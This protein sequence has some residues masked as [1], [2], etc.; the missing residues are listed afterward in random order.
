[1]KQNITGNG[2]HVQEINRMLSPGKAMIKETRILLLEDIPSDAELN[3]RELR[4]ANLVYTSKH[5]DTKEAFL[6]ALTNFSP[7][8][9]LS[10]YGLPQFNG[11][12]ALQL[13]KELKLDIPFI[14]V[15]GSLTEEV[16]VACMKEGAAD[17]ILKSSLKRLPSAVLNA[18]E[19]HEANRAKEEAFAALR[20]AND[21]LERRVE[22]RTAE[23]AKTNLFLREEIVVRKRA[24][25][26][27]RRREK[28][29]ADFVDNATIGLHWVDG[30]GTILWANKA[31]LELLGYT[32]EEY[33]GHHVAEFYADADVITD[34]LQ[35]L[36]ANEE[37]H[38]YEARLRCKDGSIR[39]VHINS[40]VYWEDGK[41]VHTRCFTRDIT[42]RRIAEEALRQAHD[43]LEQRVEQ[44]TAELVAA[45]SLLKDEIRER[46]RA[47]KFLLE[48][49]MRFHS[50][51]EY[52]PIG[53]GLA[54][55]EGRWLQV[56]DSFCEIV[57]YTKNELLTLDFQTITHP[58]DL[59][60]TFQYQ[61]RM[62]TG[63]VKTC[64]IEKRYI[65]K[66]GHV[67]WALTNVSLL[68]DEQNKPLYFISQ[69]QDVTERKRAEEALKIS[70]EQLR[71]S[72]K[73]EAVGQLAG[74]IAHDFN[75]L[76]T[77]INGYSEL[78]LRRLAPDSP[79]RN[80][81]EEI[82]K[83][84]ERAA[85]LTRQLLAFSRKQVLQ[86]K[87]LNLNAI[88]TDMDKMLR[89]LIGA[90]VDILT[91][92][93]SA[94]G[95]VKADAG[96]LEQVLMNLAVNARD[97]MPA[98]GKLT[99]QT[100]NVELSEENSQNHTS[101]KPGRYVMLAVSDTG[102][103]MD[104]ETQSR[105]FEPFFT[106]KEQGKGTGLGLSTVYGIV[107]QS[108]GNIQIYSE[109]GKGTTFKIHLPRVD[110]TIDTPAP[111]KLSETAVQAVETVL[112]VE[113]EP[114]VRQLSRQ[115]LE[116]EGYRVFEAALASEALQFC[117]NYKDEIQI[118][119]TDMVMPE[120]NG[121][122]L[123]KRVAVLRPEM[124]VLFTSG[125]MNES[126]IHNGNHGTGEAFLEKPFTPVSLADKVREVLS[127][128][129]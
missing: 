75:N 3:Q 76:L 64:Q 126:I 57:G 50:A 63:E 4:K 107:Q 25:A 42:E 116:G 14:L 27:L 84:G 45:N 125:Y 129:L 28:E 5:V 127:A 128:P 23:L 47:E 83:A 113:D 68:R 94:L 24:E 55:P 123:A 69:I 35:R 111:F 124:K 16:A 85:N 1:M 86:P 74:G 54:S 91:A 92:L 53:I 96:Q 110:E 97:A 70:E 37:L 112:L 12:E 101:V 15:T 38:D 105:I 41:F 48:S 61:R 33:I 60:D 8:V 20:K 49:E 109:I 65:H 122:E 21:E 13:L 56:N 77:A 114:S 72:Q 120:M 118:M 88:V 104:A 119:V 78:T 40:N 2:N 66:L 34:I 67:V 36:T 93:D 31:E 44:R 10:D 99:I 73:L 58:E 103:G 7:D 89:R 106:T 59:A 98:G 95:Q 11:L 39:Y 80:N 51:F 32:H 117:Q 22:Q 6:E 62:L 18:L 121:R 43:E 9:I 102:T 29:L 82:K 115:V 46:Q 26:A 71:Q 79:V 87:V 52:A 19:K 90:D 30:N 108:G 81:I 100:A 17:Y